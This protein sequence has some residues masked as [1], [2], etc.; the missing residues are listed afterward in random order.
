[1]LEQL[2]ECRKCQRDN[3]DCRSQ[4]CTGLLFADCDRISAQVEN[5]GTSWKR[6]DENLAELIRVVNVIRCISFRPGV[7]SITEQ[8][9]QFVERIYQD[10]IE[11]ASNLKLGQS[12]AH[13]E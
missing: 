8:A 11:V 4:S 3:G 10:A 1:M 6:G 12:K 2:I 5:A 7:G 13:L 9:G